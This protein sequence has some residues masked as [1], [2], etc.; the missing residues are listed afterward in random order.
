RQ[1]TVRVPA[2][3]QSTSHPSEKPGLRDL[4]VGIDRN[5]QGGARRAPFGRTFVPCDSGLVPF[6]RPRCVDAIPLGGLRFFGLGDVG[7]SAARRAPGR[8]PPLVDPF[9]RRLLRITRTGTGD[10][11]EPDAFR[12]LSTDASRSS[13]SRTPDA[14]AAVRDLGGRGP[15]SAEPA[16]LVR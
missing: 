7:G 15:S 6:W 12:V 11:P 13:V 4:H 8:G 5:A 14:G 10:G 16:A 9:A 3:H 2:R 1:S